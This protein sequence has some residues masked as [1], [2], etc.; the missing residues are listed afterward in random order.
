[1]DTLYRHTQRTPDFHLH[2]QWFMLTVV[3]PLETTQY[4]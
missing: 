2:V 1:M 4:V 3:Y